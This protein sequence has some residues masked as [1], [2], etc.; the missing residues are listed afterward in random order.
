MRSRMMAVVVGL[1]L[2]GFSG[3][4]LA[5]TQINIATVTNPDLVHTKA[6]FWFKECVEKAAPGKLAVA[7]HHSASLGSETQ[8]LQQIQLGTTQMSVCTTGPIEAFVP[9]IKALEMPFVFPSYEAA[10]IVLDGPIG[11]EL[12]KKFEK[13]GFVALAFLDN[14]FRNVTNSKR[15]VKTPEDLKALKIRTMEA[16]THLAI[17]RAIGANPTPMAWPIFT[18]LQQGVIDGQENPISVIHG[19]KLPE[20]GQKYLTL[21][22]HVYSALV[23]VANKAFIDGLPAAERKVVMDCAR[24]A[25]LQ[26]RSHIRDNEAKQIAE[27]KAA[28]MQVE[29]KPDLEAFRKATAPVI[30]SASGDT[31]KLVEQIKQAVK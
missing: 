14:G 16:P 13:S 20:A 7:V 19:S 4:V 25:S 3:G 21:S 1:C 22:R 10:D 2:I 12:G 27:L 28:G 31:K 30:E 17:W 11:Q 29:D 6:A 23:F 8:V 18:Q 15:P 9:E 24:S 5:Q 26:G